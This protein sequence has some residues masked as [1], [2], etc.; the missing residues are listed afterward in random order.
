MNTQKKISMR[1]LLV[2]FLFIAFTL[3][4]CNEHIKPRHLVDSELLGWI[5]RKCSYL[6]DEFEDSYFVCLHDNSISINGFNPYGTLE[7]AVIDYM[8]Q[9]VWLG[10]DGFREKAIKQYCDRFN[11]LYNEPDFQ[12]YLNHTAGWR[13]LED[14]SR[15]SILV[16]NYSKAAKLYQALLE[17]YFSEYEWYVYD[18]VSVLNWMYD[19]DALADAYTGFLVE[20]EVG[21]GYYVLLSLTEYK[22]SN[23]YSVK[24]LYKGESLTALH[25][26]YE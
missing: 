10:T 13:R 2:L 5:S 4:G 19:E 15:D 14:R 1:R 24:I 12:S 17:S 8:S 9:E 25:N 7:R 22:E 23:R 21:Y 6:F 16:C 20:Y 26:C 18:D 11:R 3:S